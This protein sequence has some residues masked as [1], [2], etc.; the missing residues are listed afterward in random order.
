[1]TNM[2]LIKLHREYM[3]VESY[4]LISF[5]ANN[6]K[7][8]LFDQSSEENPLRQVQETLEHMLS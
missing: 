4:E 8:E 1:M 5:L 7:L 2:D 3:N 6:L